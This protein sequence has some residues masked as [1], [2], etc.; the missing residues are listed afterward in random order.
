MKKTTLVSLIVLLASILVLSPAF[1]E[2]MKFYH[3]PFIGKWNPTEDPLLIDD[4]GFQDIQNLRRDGKHLKGVN[5]HT[6]INTTALSTYPYLLTGFHFRKDQ[7]AESHVIVYGGNAF[8]P[9]AGRLYQNTTAIPTAGDFSGTVLHTPSAYNNLWRFSTA[10]A[11]N[12]MASNGDETLIWGGNE[13]EATSFISSSVEV[14]YQATNANDFTNVV[15]NTQQ[16]TAEVATIRKLASS[17]LLHFD[18]V[19]GST[20]ITDVLGLTWTANS[21]AQLTTNNYRFGT[22]AGYFDGTTGYVRAGDNDAFRFS[23]DFTVDFWVFMGDLPVV[24]KYL[25]DFRLSGSSTN[26]FMIFYNH[27]MGGLGVYCGTAGV[28]QGPTLDTSN[29]WHIALTRSGT[30]IKLFVNGTQYGSTWT[31][32]VNFSDGSPTIGAALDGSGSI[33]AVIDE[34]NIN[35]SA[36]LWTSNFTVPTGPYLSS[37]N[38]FLVGSKRPLQG[39]KFYISS[40][41]ASTSTLT[42]QEWNGVN[43]QN[44]AVTDGTASGGKAL[45]QTGSVTFAS[46]VTSSKPRYI[47]GLSLYWYQF[48]LTAGQASI[49][50]LTV[51]AP[52]Q[53]IKNIWDGSESLPAKVLKYDGTT[54]TDYT[55]ESEDES[56]IS[57]VDISALGTSHYLLLG[58]A[59]PMQALT[60]SMVAGDENDNAATMNGSYWNGSS[61][62]AM[63]AKNDSTSISSKSLAK[64]GVVTFQPLEKGSEFT[65][66]ISDEFPLYY[67][68]IAFSATLSASVKIGEIRGI[69]APQ[70]ISPYQ[71]SDTF[72]SRLFLFNEKSGARNKAIYSTTNAPDIWNGSDSGYLYFGDNTDLTSSAVVYNVFSVLVVE[73]MIVTKKNETW[74][75]SG[76]SPPNWTLMRMSGNIGNVA[77]L[78]MATCDITDVSIPNNDI[79]R[80]VAIWVS[81]KGPVMSDGSNIYPI[82]DE[83]KCYWDPNDARFI[84]LTMQARSV[85]WYDVANRSYKLL[86]ASGS[87]ATYLNTELEYSL[88]Y[89]EWTKVYRE[90]GSGANPL[91]SGWLVYDTNG[92]SYT[93]GGG[94]DG[95][96]YRLENGYTWA[97][98]AIAQ[99]VQTKDLMLDSENPLLKHT[100]VN[101]LR[102]LY[103]KKSGTSAERI[104]TAHYG[105]RNLT[106]S[107]TGS[108][109]VPAYTLL[110]TG[111]IYTKDCTLGPFLLHSFKFSTTASTV[112]NGQEILGFGVY[113]QSYPTIISN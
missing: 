19:S 41:N 70:T 6:K 92:L 109:N 85:G 102:I 43:W 58:F 66:S 26:G 95:Y 33:N 75:L 54:Y 13:I 52:I 97:G 71:F 14:L 37:N 20:T 101:Y 112:A 55:A 27:S 93:Y 74:R 59:S 61:W 36:A 50:Y 12:M 60:F 108:Q 46:T 17:S 64:N 4:Y 32:D 31:S 90:D 68:K 103:K 79:K 100:T 57:Y 5:G 106:V 2:P 7:P 62:T 96:T 67:Y 94:K 111:P 29:W 34:F 91:Q 98:T 65:L 107:G 35:N 38:Y 47:S 104:T 87:G 42:A 76:D 11:G 8:T 88:K 40:G 86:I 10:P 81:D 15:N 44:L 80:S 9:T 45:A 53:S 3:F 49:Y 83:I 56:M 63:P 82:Y 113:Y 23:G 24:S 39:V 30:S 16:S 73:Q 84:P 21:P 78:S 22:S 77:P 69:P 99:Y 105:D 72:Q 28:I 51:D 1:A 110:S 89:K 18:G 48:Y 25:V